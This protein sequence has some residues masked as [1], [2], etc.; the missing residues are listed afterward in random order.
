MLMVW[1]RKLCLMFLWRNACRYSRDVYINLSFPN[2][3][4]IFFDFDTQSKIFYIFLSYRDFLSNDEN[5]LIRSSVDVEQIYWE[6]VMDKCENKGR[7]MVVDDD[8]LTLKNLRRILEKAG[9]SVS[10]FK[11]P[12]RALERLE[13]QPCD[14]IISDLRMPYMDGL[15]LLNRAKCLVPGIQVI[16]ITG[17]ASLD[18]AVEATKL[19]AFYYL[20]KPFTPNQVRALVREALEQKHLREEG[21]RQG[22]DPRSIANYPVIIGKSPKISQVEEVIRQIGPSDCNVLVT[23]ES[24]TGKE[25]V[26][27]AVHAMS[28]RADGPFVAFNCGAFSEDLIANELFGHEKEAFTGAANRKAGLLETADGGTVFLDEVG[29][30][31]GTMQVKLLR[32]IQEREL[33]RVGG[34]RPVPF[35]VRI[36]AST[37]KDLRAAVDAALFRQDL[38][39]RLNVVNIELPPLRERKEDIR[40]LAYHLL[41]KFRRRTNKK[42]RGIS[43]DAMTVLEAYAFPGNVRELENIIERAVAICQDQT[44]RARDLPHDLTDLELYSY[45][46]PGGDFLTLEEIEQDYIRHVLKRTGGV[47][48][49]TAEI[50]GIDRASLWRK[51]K[52]YD[53]E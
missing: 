47:R 17:Y 13:G 4:Q 39:F 37:S 21:F 14:L 40:L 28:L 48:K 3:E 5:S 26:A 30:M 15:S 9:H 35:D 42:I 36:V 29:E 31:I 24:G 12:V 6:K 51:I 53:L 23:G 38:F 44:I 10:T 22:K 49:R 8:H 41:G 50:L 11:N 16:L 27:R 19:G 45:Q 1:C 52:K 34:N 46:R 2:I 32:V 18:G 33:Y 25:L 20:A 7:I 43:L